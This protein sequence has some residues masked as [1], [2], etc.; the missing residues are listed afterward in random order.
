M[1]EVC[2]NLGGRHV[3]TQQQVRKLAEKLASLKAGVRHSYP[4]KPRIHPRLLPEER[5]LIVKALIFLASM[6]ED[7][8]D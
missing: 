8:V 7:G 5:D 2:S 1:G 4:N 3:F 6:R